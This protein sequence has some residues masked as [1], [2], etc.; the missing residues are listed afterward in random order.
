MQGFLN[1]GVHIVHALE[2][3][4]AYQD[5]EGGYTGRYSVL[6]RGSSDKSPPLAAF[7]KLQQTSMWLVADK[8]RTVATLGTLMLTSLAKHMAAWCKSTERA[9]LLAKSTLGRLYGG[10]PKLGVPTIMENQME[11]KMENEMETGFI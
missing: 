10:F 3:A 2:T 1:A 5:D 11:K 9:D 8:G 6:L 4:V 7:W